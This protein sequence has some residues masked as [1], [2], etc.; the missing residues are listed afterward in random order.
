VTRELKLS[1]LVGFSLVLVVTVLI[2]DH[3]SQAGTARLAADVAERPS[4]TPAVPA[5]AIEP[6]IDVPLLGG[7]RF[8]SADPATPGFARAFPDATRSSGF[9]ASPEADVASEVPTLVLGREEPRVASLTSREAHS[10]LISTVLK[11]GGRVLNGE[12]HLPAAAETQTKTLPTSPGRP[13]SVIVPTT[14]ATPP[15][16]VPQAPTQTT[17]QAPVQASASY[18]VVAGDSAFKI[19]KRYYGDGKVWKRLLESNPGRISA[20]GN[21]RLGSKLTIPGVQPSTVGPIAAPSTPAGRKPTTVAITGKP[22][23]GAVKPSAAATYTVKRGDTLAA[24]AQ[25][26]LGS[27]K[28]S[29]DILELNKGVIRDPNN[30]PLGAVLKMP[31]A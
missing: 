4:M 24:I 25:R 7:D 30:V 12:I 28:R 3:L 14:L 31:E 13:P 1:L 2:S 20:D 17:P 21:V 27:V 9:P 8:A 29:K 23:K 6:D 5:V 26:E 19:A 16:L 15:L 22:A 10:D 11:Q 18:T